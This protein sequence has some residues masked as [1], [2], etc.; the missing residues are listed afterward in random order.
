MEEAE[1]QAEEKIS[2]F[3]DDFLR[4]KHIKFFKRCLAVLP[5]EYSSLDTSR[6]TVA[7]FAIS[8][9]DVLDA[10]DC[11]E[12][13]KK[14]IIEWIYSHQVPPKSDGTNGGRCGFRGSSTA[15]CNLKDP[16]SVHEYEYGH[17]AMTYTALAMLLILG[18]D[19]S[20]INRPAIIEG[21]RHLQ[22]EDGSFCPTYLGSENDMR[23]IYCACCISFI[24][25]DWSGI[26]IE[27]AVQYIRN[28]QSYDYGIAQGPHLESHG[29]STFC[30]IASLSLMNQLDKVFTK[31]QLEKLIRWCIFRQKSGFH[32]RPNK[33]VD[34]CYAFW[35]GASLEI[36]NSFK[37]IDFT[38]NRDYLMQTQANVTGGFSKW[39]GIHPDALHSYFGVCGLSLMN[40]RGLVPIHAALNFSQRAADHLQRLHDTTLR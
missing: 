8:A 11:I 21:L 30:A 1:I 40:E 32:G 37:M 13:E 7:F 5:S 22:L 26:N 12:K 16:E 38:A 28:S 19:L 34:T 39:P 25:N 15:G 31:S 9:L 20:R 10:L 35:V 2:A 33:P 36:L 23:F 29:G 4:E 6:V 14:D 3:N 24:L 27:K 17:I 18:D